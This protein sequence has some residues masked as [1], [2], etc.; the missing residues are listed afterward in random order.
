M[1]AFRDAVM[2][3]CSASPRPEGREYLILREEDRSLAL[4]MEAVV[5][6]AI[7]MK[8]SFPDNVN[9]TDIFCFRGIL[10]LPHFPEKKQ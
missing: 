8:A 5:E 4:A 6:T 3:Q 2:R 7:Y 1:E 10:S 9:H